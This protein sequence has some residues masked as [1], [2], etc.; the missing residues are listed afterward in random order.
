MIIKTSHY[1]QCRMDK[2][3]APPTT[4]TSTNVRCALLQV[5]PTYGPW[6]KKKKQK[7]KNGKDMSPTSRKSARA[8]WGGA[9]H[10]RRS[11]TTKA[12]IISACRRHSERDVAPVPMPMTKGAF[13]RNP[14]T[15]EKKKNG[16]PRRSVRC[17]CVVWC[18]SAQV[19]SANA[20]ELKPW[21]RAP[22]PWTRIK[23]RV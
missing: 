7:R 3:K 5:A 1:V 17:D 4:T 6:C 20:T 21:H 18:C 13:T 14:K 8:G 16:A 11:P 10:V 19:P 15:G 22:I 2:K 12:R 23:F 9:K